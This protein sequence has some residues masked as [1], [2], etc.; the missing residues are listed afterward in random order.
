MFISNFIFEF[1]KTLHWP[2]EYYDSKHS[3]NALI[4]I[5]DDQ[6]Q[7]HEYEHQQLLILQFYLLF[8][9]GQFMSYFGM[10]FLQVSVVESASLHSGQQCNTSKILLSLHPYFIDT[11][12]KYLK[13]PVLKKIYD[14]ANFQQTT[15]FK[16]ISFKHA[17]I[18]PLLVN[19]FQALI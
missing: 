4:N 18:F 14:I 16:N 2:F 5:H 6:L 7:G 8:I 12:G 9:L 11:F 10:F 17:L 15:I 1:L 19:F 3:S 13:V